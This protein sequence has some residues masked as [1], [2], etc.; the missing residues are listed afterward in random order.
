[1]SYSSSF[2]SSILSFEDFQTGINGVKAKFSLISMPSQNSY[3]ERFLLQATLVPERGFL[4]IDNYQTVFSEPITVEDRYITADSGDDILVRKAQIAYHKLKEKIW[5]VT[6]GTKK[7]EQ[8]L[9]DF[10]EDV[11][12]AQ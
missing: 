6:T 12:N 2:L 3:E 10:L 9:K 8:V 1:M 5:F 4:T 11:I 7:P